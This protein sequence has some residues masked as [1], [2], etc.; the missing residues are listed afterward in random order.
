MR[1]RAATALF[2]LIGTRI[3]PIPAQ[4]TPV[5]ANMPS[6][7]RNALTTDFT[8]SVHVQ[9]IPTGARTL[10][11]WIPLPSNSKWQTVENL[12]ID[13]PFR[14]QITQ[15]KQYGNRMIFVRVD[16]PQNPFL[17]TAHFRVHRKAVRTDHAGGLLPPGIPPHQPR[18]R[19]LGADRNVPVG[20]KYHALAKE[21]VGNR[22][23]PEAQ[24]RAIFAHVIANLQYD[25][26]KE[27]PKLGEGDVAFVCDYKKGNC[28]DLHSYLIALARSLGIPAYL[29]FGFPISGIPLSN[30]LVSEGTLGGYHC[31]MWFQLPGREWAALDASDARRWQDAGRVDLRDFLLGNLLVERSAVAFSR[32]RDIW[33]APRQKAGPLNYF[34]APYGE[35]DGA[36]LK[37]NWELRYRLSSD[38]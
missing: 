31:W 24:M 17:L 8:L 18:K 38:P 6:V 12:S 10:H 5:A 29:E 3:P 7:L 26:K 13:S 1:W 33:L 2:L 35:A 36:A 32:G 28:S 4:Q 23:E 27:S 25:Y 34:I 21:V 16:R 9:R 14:Y 15:E 19:D 22:S 37:V 20:G 30:P 11:L